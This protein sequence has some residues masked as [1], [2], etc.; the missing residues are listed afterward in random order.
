MLAAMRNR[1]WYLYGAS[2]ALA[3]VLYYTVAHNNYLF[4]V[5][6]ASAPLFMIVAV[7]L[8]R[9]RRRIPWYLLAL[10]LALFIA[11]DVIVYHYERFF[12]IKVPYPSI[13]DVLYL[14]VYPC[15]ALG[16]LLM[17]RYRTPGRDWASFLD[18]LMVT[19]GVGTVSWV[20]LIEPNWRASHSELLTKLTSISYPVMD[21][22]VIT[23]AA[24]LAFGAG[25][26]APS[27]FLMLGAACVLF[28]T[29]SLYGWS[30]L[31]EPYVP[32]SG[33][34]ELGWIAFYTGY[35]MAA[36]HSSM[37]SL[38]ER[39][40]L[41][42]DRAGWGR[43]ALLG[44]TA[45]L[46][47][48]LRLA[49]NALEQKVDD[50][51][52]TGATFV[53]FVLVMLR[54]AGLIHLRE[55]DAARE[56]ALRE[57]GAALVTAT[58]R[59]NI[60]AAAITAMQS[61]AGDRAVVRVYQ[62]DPDDCARYRVVAGGGAAPGNS[63][64]LHD[65]GAGEC[66]PLDGKPYN[67]ILSA[68]ARLRGVLGLA[69]EQR[70]VFVA[71]L[72][73]GEEPGELM[74]VG[75][76]PDVPPGFFGALV[77]L[78]SQVALALESAQLTEK[79]LDQR[80]EARFASLVKNSS[81]LVSVV[82]ADTSIRYATPSAE[83]V[84]GYSPSELEGKRFVDLVAPEDRPRVLSVL[85]ST[86]DLE[87]AALVEFRI[88]HRG[89]SV[90][91]VEA[92][93]TNLLDDPNVR[94]IVLNMRDISE[95]KAFEGQLT[96]QA[97]HDPVTGLAN[98][99]LFRNHVQHALD[100]RR[101]NG[102]PIAV[103]F[104]DLDD[105]KTINDSLGHA[106]GDRVLR[107]VGER[108]RAALRAADTAARFG[109][110]EFAVLI[111]GGGEDVQ[112]SDVAERLLRLLEKP[113]QIE[114]KDL[115]VR[116]SIGI[117]NLDMESADDGEVEDLLRSADVAMYIAKE[118]GKGQYQIYEPA[119]H[120]RL[121]GRL[122]LKADLQRALDQGEFALAYQPVVDLRTGAIMGVEALLR[123]RHPARGM[124]APAEFVPLAEE[125]GQIIQIGQWVL[126]EACRYAAA[127]RRG[128]APSLHVA[129]NLSARQL[130]DPSL[131][132]SMRGMLDDTGLDP[133][134]LVIEITESVMMRDMDTAI[135]RLHELKALGVQLAI[136]DFGTG[137]S[138]LNY[139][140][141]FPVD[142]LKIDKSFIDGVGNGG[143][144]Q[145]LALTTAMVD[146]AVILKLRPVAEGIE[147]IEQL[148]RLRKMGCGLGQGYLFSAPVEPR[149][150]EPLIAPG[151]RWLQE[152][153]RG[154][155]AGVGPPATI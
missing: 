138:S 123:W 2:V 47:T 49:Q 109:G 101:R 30:L 92:L 71:V 68:N 139:I 29:D 51:V 83:K 134:A 89:G 121:L 117:V 120:D 111:E 102:Q 45:L 6:G 15:L 63:F 43:L 74:L 146:L 94:G 26:R 72:S 113:F 129:V 66:L 75:T 103:L 87:K 17:V 41:R 39:A 9:P 150:L 133:A 12:G 136:D 78:S 33:Y 23:V 35:G 118:R 57:A 60:R 36:L 147:R 50:A 106:A 14:S 11:G 152:S 154:S 52:L 90:R 149:E 126:W 25:R 98:R 107:E 27:L 65:L 151:V 100:R 104:M 80:S 10:G 130:Q 73:A 62:R 82:E 99:A 145:G 81:D 137:Y 1:L 115:F 48:G 76:R 114:G 20:F 116:A 84:L 22:L 153:G 54:M 40:I 108:V 143:Q 16:L 55:Q 93:R 13:A 85:A 148:D 142:I 127:L 53:L 119:M 95:R 105:F 97:F 46:P 34:L 110:D 59:D 140:R 31:H 88:L 7:E 32:G 132:E 144:G 4:N 86:L 141:R 70:S 21:L 5:I 122:E 61:L 112:A 91:F 37:G 64:S 124:V 38:T 79:L 135:K 44:V 67:G 128:V 58:S 42:D 19:V 56:R 155:W 125:T 131:L 18:S 96:Y 69:D 28:V 24:R 3:T 77:A 8:Q